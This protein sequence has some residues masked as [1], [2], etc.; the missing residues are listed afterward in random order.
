[1]HSRRSYSDLEMRKR[2][3]KTARRCLEGGMVVV[4]RIS[5]GEAREGQVEDV[6]ADV[7]HMRRAGFSVIL[8]I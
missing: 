1:M 5:G 8:R 2:R 7:N 6:S 4:L 3:R